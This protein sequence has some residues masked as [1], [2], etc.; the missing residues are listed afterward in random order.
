MSC[1]FSFFN[2]LDCSGPSSA[3]GTVT[4]DGA[5][6]AHPSDS[7][8]PLGYGK[9]AFQAT[10]SGDANYVSSV[11]E[12]EPFTVTTITFWKHVLL[13]PFPA[14]SFSFQAVGGLW[15]AG[16]TISVPL[17]SPVSPIASVPQYISEGLY[18]VNEVGTVG[19][20][21]LVNL[22]CNSSEG[23]D[24]KDDPSNPDVL[25]DRVIDI[26]VVGGTHWDCNFVNFNP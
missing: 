1:S 10:Y 18:A 11:S 4:L 12:C 22:W 21:T 19:G 26:T 6:V 17:N 25:D 13:L 16:T 20:W 7:V 9:Y 5:G 8:G 3:A 14:A 24:V 15:G 2:N 23:D